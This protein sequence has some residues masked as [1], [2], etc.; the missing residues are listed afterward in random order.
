[1]PKKNTKSAS[2]KTKPTK[3]R[4][5][6]AKSKAKSRARGKSRPRGRPRKKALF[7]NLN[8]CTQNTNIKSQEA[9]IN[10]D[11]QDMR[12]ENTRVSEIEK[13]VFEPINT[14]ITEFFNLDEQRIIMDVDLK[15]PENDKNNEPNMRDTSM[16]CQTI[17]WF[18]RK[19]DEDDKKEH[20]RTL[21]LGIHCKTINIKTIHFGVRKYEETIDGMN[22]TYLKGDPLAYNVISEDGFNKNWIYS[23]NIDQ[24]EETSQD[25]FTTHPSFH[26][27]EASQ[28]AKFKEDK[29]NGF[30]YFENLLVLNQDDVFPPDLDIIIDYEIKDIWDVGLTLRNTNHHSN[31]GCNL[32]T[33]HRYFETHYWLPWI[34]K[35]EQKCKWKITIITDKDNQVACSGFLDKILDITNSN[36]IG[37][38]YEVKDNIPAW[39]VA[40]FIAHNFSEHNS[41]YF[42]SPTKMED[43][44]QLYEKDQDILSEIVEFYQNILFR[45]LSFTHMD[46]IFLPNIFISPK[47]KKRVLCYSNLCFLDEKLILNERI[48]ENRYESYFQI[49]YWIASNLVFENEYSDYWLAEGIYQELANAY[50]VHKWGYMM[51]RYRL[52][53]R[54]EYWRDYIKNG[55]EIYPLSTENCG[56]PS[57]VQYNEFYF[58]KSGLWVHFIEAKISKEYFYKILR[59]VLENWKL[60]NIGIST[61]DFKKIFK[62]LTGLSLRKFLKNW[63]DS[64]G[65]ID[66]SCSHEYVKKNNSMNLEITQRNPFTHYLVR[67]KYLEQQQNSGDL[68]I[69]KLYS[70]NYLNDLKMDQQWEEYYVEKY[71]NWCRFFDQGFNI[72]IYETDGYL[73]KG[74]TKDIELNFDKPYLKLNFPLR[75]R[76]KKISQNKKKEYENSSVHGN[77][78][79]KFE[80]GNNL[81]GEGKLF[82]KK[83]LFNPQNLESSVVW[84]RIDPEVQILRN[85]E[86]YQDEKHWHYQLL[87][88]TDIIG[89]YEAIE[90][91]KKQPT[92]LSYNALEYVAK[93]TQ[94]F[95]KIRQHAIKSLVQINTKEFNKYL[96]TEKILFQIFNSYDSQIIKSNIFQILGPKYTSHHYKY[97]NNPLQYF[98]DQTVIAQIGKCKEKTTCFKKSDLLDH[99]F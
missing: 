50:T 41:K 91:L 13:P 43:Y 15:Y 82:Y 35:I 59:K 86:V 45:N 52:A 4:V 20:L 70:R 42:S 6:K 46:L 27:F 38:W 19:V 1:M 11:D 14:S 30:L 98:I 92:E 76:V 75:N 34:D 83:D 87:K 85:I 28:N 16:K 25:P 40:F 66:I 84:I 8:L 77:K 72:I 93:N 29:K 97:S 99:N 65:W 18:S 10:I 22:I 68:N 56:H 89:Q 5:K 32:A 31:Q 88:D 23:P 24:N 33:T 7:E 74:E 94:Y 48:L 39:K 36:K 53:K 80:P 95:F 26:Q 58:V 78:C 3:K 2:Q 54:I 71:R 17:L 79:A 47:S 60:K 81:K 63:I 49:A 69:H 51:Y 12:Q 64:T 21:N 9:E 67:E 55:K 73:I 37:Y 44:I 61:L 57:H 62:E 96:S 90:A